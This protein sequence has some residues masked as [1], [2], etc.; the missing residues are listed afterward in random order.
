MLLPSLWGR[1]YSPEQP[2]CKY[3]C[4]TLLRAHGVRRKNFRLDLMLGSN[5][6]QRT[7]TAVAMAAHPIR[8]ESRVTIISRV[9]PSRAGRLRGLFL[10]SMPVFYS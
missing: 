5:M 6:K 10:V 1:I 7:G 9:M 4:S 8:S 3:S 2:C